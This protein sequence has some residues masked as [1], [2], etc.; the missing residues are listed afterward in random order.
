MKGNWFLN[1]TLLIVVVA[2]YVLTMITFAPVES[3]GPGRS[4]AGVLIQAVSPSISNETL[5]W[6]YLPMWLVLM[7]P[8][9]G[10]VLRKKNR[11][12]WHLLWAITPIGWLVI[13]CFKNRSVPVSQLG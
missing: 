6:L 7:L 2:T 1:S 13:L 5:S 4:V 8:V 10:W 11:S 12:L 3:T 9:E